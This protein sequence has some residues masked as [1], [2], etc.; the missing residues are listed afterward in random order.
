MSAVSPYGSF[1]DDSIL[2]NFTKDGFEILVDCKHFNPEE[3]SVRINN[4]M[5]YI[6][7]EHQERAPGYPVKYIRRKINKQF[8]VPSGFNPETIVS[9]LS[10]QGILSVRCA[11][12]GSENYHF[13]IHPPNLR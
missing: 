4:N 9:G 5:I 2:P 13:P 3:I 8:N 1:A 7:A 10:P 6:N 12:P 11:A